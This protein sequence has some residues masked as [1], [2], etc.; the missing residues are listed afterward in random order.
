MLR[1]ICVRHEFI[2]MSAQKG[3]QEP[4][5]GSGNDCVLRK[6]GGNLGGKGRNT[7]LLTMTHVLTLPSRLVSP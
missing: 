1:T 4:G 3:G 7:G 5:G 2:M 6:E